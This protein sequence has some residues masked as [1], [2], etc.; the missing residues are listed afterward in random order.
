[1]S[2]QYQRINEDG[3]YGYHDNP[4]GFERSQKT[5]GNQADFS[6]R[7]DDNIRHAW[8]GNA[9]DEN[10]RRQDNQL[11][12]YSD[13]DRF[14]RG[15]YSSLPDY[16]DYGTP[17]AD[18][19]EATDFRSGQFFHRQE[20]GQTRGQ[21][22]GS[23]YSDNSYGRN[24]MDAT[25]GSSAGR[26][27]EAERRISGAAFTGINYSDP[28]RQG[29]SG[30]MGGGSFGSGGGSFG[31]GIYSETGTMGTPRQMG[32]SRGWTPDTYRQQRQEETHLSGSPMRSG[33][34]GSDYN[35]GSDY[36][37]T[38]WTGQSR[39]FTDGDYGTSETEE[40]KDRLPDYKRRGWNSRNL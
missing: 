19:Q 39:S 33:I 12:G 35:D 29:S 38:T 1:M 32:S 14:S 24:F 7:V 28:A 2:K 37:L 8:E 17:P 34:Y 30:S 27:S 4:Y 10:R 26:G 22:A 5:G 20:F 31:G 6:G 18:H 36:E 9:G 15:R 11:S 25:Y 3:G 21:S 23:S 13:V 16:G 40:Q